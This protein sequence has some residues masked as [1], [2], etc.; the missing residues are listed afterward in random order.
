MRF[1]LVATDRRC[2]LDHVDTFEISGADE[3]STEWLGDWTL[4]CRTCDALVVDLMESAEIRV[5][6]VHK[7]VI[8]YVISVPVEMTIVGDD[9]G[10]PAEPSKGKS[11][12]AGFLEAR[13]SWTGGRDEDSEP[14]A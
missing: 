10:S 13:L 14:R 5:A 7:S 9:C 8:G 6:P 1:T 12:P 2:Y 11:L 4:F 3:P